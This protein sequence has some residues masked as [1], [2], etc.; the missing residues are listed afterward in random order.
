M[1][2]MNSNTRCSDSIWNWDNLVKYV[3]MWTERYTFYDCFF[4]LFYFVCNTSQYSVNW[5]KMW[6]WI[7]VYGASLSALADSQRGEF[8]S[9]RRLPS[10]PLTS[11]LSGRA[12]SLSDG[13]LCGVKPDLAWHFDGENILSSSLYHWQVKQT[14]DQIFMEVAGK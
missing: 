3:Y 9:D 10:P 11:I 1:T 2:V 12:G 4:V 6:C 8:A 7:P 13:L 5:C 14:S